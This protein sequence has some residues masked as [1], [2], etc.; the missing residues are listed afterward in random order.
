MY[1]LIYSLCLTEFKI[2]SSEEVTTS[3]VTADYWNAA[4][5]PQLAHLPQLPHP[6]SSNIT[7]TGT[8]NIPSNVTITKKAGTTTKIGMHTTHKSNI[9][10]YTF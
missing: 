6:L 9:F 2:Y 8:A 1:E 10:H 4:P 7:V 3:D 5:H